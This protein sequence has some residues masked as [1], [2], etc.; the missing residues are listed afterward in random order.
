MNEKFYESLGNILKNRRIAKKLSQEKV[1]EML[2]FTKATVSYW[3]SGKRKIYADTLKDY[4][5]ILGCLPQDVF[6]EMEDD[7]K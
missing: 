3:E 7:S 1:G 5:R 6:S 4:C 2:G